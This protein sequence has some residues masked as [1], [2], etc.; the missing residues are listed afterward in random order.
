MKFQ[1]I[2]LIGLAIVLACSA[3]PGMAFSADSGKGGGHATGGE[4]GG[5]GSGKDTGGLKL[6]HGLSAGHPGHAS[7]VHEENQGNRGTDQRFGGGSGIVGA[8]QI[9]EGPGENPQG[10]FGPGPRYRNQF[11]YWGG[12]TLPG[13]GDGGGTEGDGGTPTDPGTGTGD[14]GGTTTNPGADTE[15]TTTNPGTSTGETATDPGVNS[16]GGGGTGTAFHL[17]GEQRCADIGALNAA[18]RLGGKNLGRILD[19]QPLLAPGT[20]LRGVSI[21]LLANYQSELE[22]E[23]PDPVLA[24]TYLGMVAKVPVTPQLI[25]RVSWALCVV[26]PEGGQNQI[27]EIAEE[28]RQSLLNKSPAR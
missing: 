23:K 20:R 26:P 3:G 11:R 18:S 15:E 21:M 19:M 9:M 6:R 1:A 24:G 22:K 14:T 13:E 12:W 16:G 4:G 5:H 17:V 8:E 27:A 7:G 25:S 10:G 2:R 28:Q